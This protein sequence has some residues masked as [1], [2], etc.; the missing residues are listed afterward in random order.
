MANMIY[1]A[2]QLA[3]REEGRPAES[4]EKKRKRR[5]K[6]PE[7][8]VQNARESGELTKNDSRIVLT[9]GSAVSFQ[10]SSRMARQNNMCQRCLPC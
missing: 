10:G 5:H 9:P 6:V 3:A 2:S 8:E 4:A 7:M 1:E